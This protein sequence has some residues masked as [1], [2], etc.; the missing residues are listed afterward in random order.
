MV[1]NLVSNYDC[2]I[3]FSVRDMTFYDFFFNFSE[4]L[5]F[6]KFK[7]EILSLV[8]G[9]CEVTLRNFKIQML[10]PKFTAK[11]LLAFEI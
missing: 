7:I 10:R 11:M 3:P 2:P 6:K 4:N 5:D 8:V 9:F 1:E